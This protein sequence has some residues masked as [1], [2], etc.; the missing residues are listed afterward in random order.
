M[1]PLPVYHFLAHRSDVEDAQFIPNSQRAEGYMGHEYLWQGTLVHQGRVYDHIGFRARGGVHRYAVGKNKWKFNFHKGHRFQ[2]YD[3][4]GRPYPV[5]WDKLNLSSVIQ[6]ANRG[7]RGE[8]GLFESASYRLFNLAGVP[9]SNTHFVHFRVIDGH[10][11]YGGNQY[12][13]DFWGLYLAIEEVDGHFLAQRDLPNG[14][15]YK[16]AD[17]TGELNNQGL[18]APTDKSDLNAF[19]HTYQTLQPDAGWWRQNLDLATYFS[20]RA[21]VEA[22]HHYDINEGKNYHYFHNPET[23]QWTVIPWDLDLTWAPRMPGDGNEPFRD[24]VLPIP[25]FQVEYQ[26]RLR[27]LRDLLFNLDQ[28]IPLIDEQAALVNTPAGSAMVDADRARWDYNPILA[29][30]RYTVRERAGQGRFYEAHPWRTFGGM[31]QL[32]KDWVVSR[33]QWIDQTLLTDPFA[34]QTPGVGYSGPPGYPAD[35]L[36]FQSTLFVDPYGAFAAMEWRAAEVVRPGLPGYTPGAPNRYEI[37]ATWQSGQLAQYQPTITLPP[38]AC[39]PGR[40][41]RVRVRMKNSLGRWSHWSPPVE[42]TTGAPAQPPATTLKITEVMYHPLQQS[43][44]HQSEF[45][46]IELKNVGDA[47]LDLSNM[48]FTVGI[49]YTFPVGSMLSPGAFA[50]LARNP[51]WFEAFY[52]FAPLGP[53]RQKLSNSGDRLTLSDAFGRTVIDLTYSDQPPWPVL[54]GGLGHSLVLNTPERNLN[55]NLASNWRASLFAGGS[56]GADDP[57]PLVI[58]EVLAHPGP[59]QAQFIELHN[60]ADFEV[61]LTGWS[62]R[63]GAGLLRPLP[64]ES[65]ASGSYRAFSVSELGQSTGSFVLGPKAGRLELVAPAVGKVRRYLHRFPYRVAPSGVSSGRYVNRAGQEKF[66]LQQLPT[67]G[68]ANAGPVVGPVVIN[69]IHYN[70]SHGLE[71][72]ELTNLTQ[73]AL[74]LFDSERP[75]N[76]W[77]IS[78]LLFQFATGVII[79]PGGKVVITSNEPAAVCTGYAVAEQVRVLGPLPLLLDDNGQHLALER[80]LPPDGEGVIP[81]MVVDE[82]SYTNLTP[83]PLAGEPGAVLER[84]RLDGY[85]DDPL[86]WR[87]G[88]VAQGVIQPAGS[89][90]VVDLCSFEAYVDEEEGIAIHWVTR[91]EQNVSE[92][93]LYRSADGRRESAEQVTGSRVAI[94]GST[95]T[96]ADYHWLDKAAG[97]NG[98]ATPPYTYWLVAA[99]PDGEQ[100]DLAFTSVRPRV[101]QAHLPFVYRN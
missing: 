39:T 20:Y 2:A 80:P 56:P 24:R 78:G 91:N 45:E 55:P 8:Q 86:N 18:Y 6:N 13:G 96:G 75:A 61:S 84:L 34:P 36:S 50:V 41:C 12:E 72:I 98:N 29:N 42:F 77:R 16:M 95:T 66:P 79:P 64:P 87:R 59:D 65:L 49:S 58:N 52:G 15:L 69:A 92:F 27:E 67:P 23:R 99:G 63:D 76:T 97:I 74:P 21:I 10:S 94:E 44:I 47:P 46:F 40:T 73:E 48:S 85:G 33:S 53:Y 9:A 17:G 54:A 90:P 81:Y 28:L 43:S 37:E 88:Q 1:R 26:N 101:Q 38:G 32:M 4:Y 3:D 30:T 7:H 5:L 93:L 62:L 70:G 25:E 60:P 51:V 89:G 22:I 11:E 31:A 35:Q 82:L 14:N 100:V 68:Q 19:L 57:L 83:W 71:Y